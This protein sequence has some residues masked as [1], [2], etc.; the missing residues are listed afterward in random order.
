MIGKSSI[1]TIRLKTGLYSQ[2]LNAVT[3]FDRIRKEVLICLIKKD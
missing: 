3:Y 2:L 1:W